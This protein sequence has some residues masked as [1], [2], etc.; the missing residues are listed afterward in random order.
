VI[1]GAF[2]LLA[3]DFITEVTENTEGTE[4]GGFTGLGLKTGGPSSVPSVFSVTS[5]MKSP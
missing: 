3:G 5:V 4:D 1:P 2:V